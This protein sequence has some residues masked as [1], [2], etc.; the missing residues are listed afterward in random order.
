MGVDTTKNRISEI[1]N[2]STVLERK[3]V[4]YDEVFTDSEYDENFW[5]QYN[6]IPLDTDVEQRLKE[7]LDKRK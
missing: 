1:V 2:D 7:A 3:I 4:K 6:F 5:Q